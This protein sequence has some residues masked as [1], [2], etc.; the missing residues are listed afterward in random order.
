MLEKSAPTKT[1]KAKS[2]ENNIVQI[3][4]KPGM[5]FAD[6]QQ[7]MRKFGYTTINLGTV[8]NYLTKTYPKYFSPIH[9]KEGQ[10]PANQLKPEWREEV[11]TLAKE[12][13]DRKG[14]P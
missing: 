7:E 12:Y 5:V 9:L 13:A 14:R 1:K 2:P 8:W 3:L 6:F 11:M 4:D 10:K